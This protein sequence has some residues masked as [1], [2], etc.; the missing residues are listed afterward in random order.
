MPTNTYRTSDFSEICFLMARSVPIHTVTRDR[1]RVTF[2]FDDSDG[3]CGAY[4]NDYVLGR[5]Q[6]SAVRIMA[7]RQRAMKIIKSV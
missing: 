6:V 7:E 3:Q 1:E 5:D 4:M 2:T